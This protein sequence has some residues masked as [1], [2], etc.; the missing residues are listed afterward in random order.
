MWFCMCGKE[1]EW[2]LGYGGLVVVYVSLVDTCLI[3]M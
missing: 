3:E 1:R 2:E